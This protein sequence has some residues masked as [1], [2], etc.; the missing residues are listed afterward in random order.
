M[1]LGWGDSRFQNIFTPAPTCVAS[2]TKKTKKPIMPTNAR[3][4]ARLPAFF[5]RTMFRNSARTPASPPIIR[6]STTLR[7]TV[8]CSHYSV[9][10]RQQ[11]PSSL[12]GTATLSLKLE[13]VVPGPWICYFSY[14]GQVFFYCS[15]IDEQYSYIRTSIIYYFSKISY[16]YVTFFSKTNYYENFFSPY[17]WRLFF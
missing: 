6:K 11:V 10:K 2:P 4:K 12:V 9:A 5:L 14:C 16:V 15:S 13:N 8:W 1:A 17:F 7:S 3:L